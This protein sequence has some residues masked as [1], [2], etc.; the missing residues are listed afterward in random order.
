MKRHRTV[1]HNDLHERVPGFVIRRRGAI[2]FVHDAAA[3]P[4]VGNFIA[5]F[6]DIGHFDFCLLPAHGDER[7]FVE[8]IREIR[9]RETGRRFRDGGEIDF[10]GKLKFFRVNAEN[11]LAPFEVG[12]IDVDLAVETPRAQQRRVEHVRAIGGGDDDYAFL[13]IKSVHFDEKRIQRLLAFVVPAAEPAPALATDGVDFVDE[14]DAGR[15]F[16][17]LFKSIA[18]AR[19]ADADEKLDEIRTRN[20]EKRHIGFSRDGAREQGFSGAGRPDEQHALGNAP[21]DFGKAFRL[22]QEIDDFGNFFFCFVATGD[23]LE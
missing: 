18:H 21:A 9:S 17:R 15:I 16:S 22:A 6:L 8:K 3:F 11:C 19:G 4:P 13:R 20:R 23:V 10:F 14:D 12:Q 7:R 1:V 5:R 2:F